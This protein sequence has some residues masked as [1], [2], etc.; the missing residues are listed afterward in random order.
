MSKEPRWDDVLKNW[1]IGDK[2]AFAL[3][4]TEW[5]T[6]VPPRHIAMIQLF[7]AES[8]CPFPVFRHSL[9]G[10]RVRKEVAYTPVTLVGIREEVLGDSNPP[11]LDQIFNILPL[12]IREEFSKNLEAI[13]QE[14][15]AAE[16]RVRLDQSAEVTAHLRQRPIGDLQREPGRLARAKG[17]LRRRVPLGTKGNGHLK[18]PKFGR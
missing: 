4:C 6:A 5:W 13:I 10:L 12:E 15:P 7:I 8:C 14:P 16:L 18:S 17:W 3:R 11:T 2:K 9:E 1:W